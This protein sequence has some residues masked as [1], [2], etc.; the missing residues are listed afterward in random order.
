MA[1]NEEL[2]AMDLAAKKAEIMRSLEGCDWL[3]LDRRPQL[4][5]WGEAIDELVA[6]GEITM[7]WREV[8]EQSTYLRLERARGA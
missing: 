7:E 5:F 6:E 1:R 4:A 8:D 3:M 2:D